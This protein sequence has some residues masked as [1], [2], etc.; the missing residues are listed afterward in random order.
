MAAQ[1][2]V[3]VLV[4]E[5]EVLW[6]QMAEAFGGRT[7]QQGDRTGSP[8]VRRQGSIG[9]TALE[10]RPAIVLV[11]QALRFLPWDG[12][13]GQSEG[14]PTARG[15]L[16]EVSD[17]VAALADS[18]SDPVVDVFLGEVGEGGQV[19]LVDPGQEVQGGADASP[20]VAVGGGGMVAA[21]WRARRSRNQF[22]NGRA[23]LACAAGLS[24]SSCSSQPGM[25][26]RSSCRSSKVPVW[27]RSWRI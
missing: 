27:T 20:Q 18:S 24:A 25:R 17:Q 1:D 12:G 10:E 6:R 21:R 4:A 8:D 14:E 15:P 11:E 9:Q 7:K 13:D 16:Q 2:Q 5:L 23:T 3:G 22:R 26:S 19:A